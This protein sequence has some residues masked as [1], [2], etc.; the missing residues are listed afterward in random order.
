MPAG[1]RSRLLRAARHRRHHAHGPRRR[2]SGGAGPATR[3]GRRAGQHADS[4]RFLVHALLAQTAAR[5]VCCEGRCGSCCCCWCWCW[6]WRCECRW[7]W[8]RRRRWCGAT[9]AT[10]R[11][12]G[13]TDA[14]LAADG[15]Q[16]A[17]AVLRRQPRRHCEQEAHVCSGGGVSM[18]S[19]PT[20][21]PT[22]VDLH[23]RALAL[24][25][26]KF[27]S[28]HAAFNIR[29]RDVGGGGARRRTARA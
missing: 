15:S 23:P 5:D 10:A 6:C 9:H 4:T 29:H 26:G 16:A 1:Q 2:D 11:H 21:T 24:F 28:R 3:V 20:A 19:K 18:H 25:G 8:R 13:S 27:T 17:G 22:Q 7:R 14:A 12:A